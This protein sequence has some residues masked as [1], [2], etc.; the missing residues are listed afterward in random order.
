MTAHHLVVDITEERST[1]APIEY[2]NY[3]TIT[4]K[5]Q[6]LT[7]FYSLNLGLPPNKQMSSRQ[8][9]KMKE[10]PCPSFNPHL[11]RIGYKERKEH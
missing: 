2:P 9:C 7:N 3:A 4:K 5:V 11:K 6:H 1:D 8:F 10:L